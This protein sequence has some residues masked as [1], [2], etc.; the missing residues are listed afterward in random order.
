LA[1]LVMQ[2]VEIANIS[3]T[4]YRNTVATSFAID[5]PANSMQRLDAYIAAGFVYSVEFSLAPP[6]SYFGLEA[7]FSPIANLVS[8]DCPSSLPPSVLPATGYDSEE[9]GDAL[10]YERRTAV[11]FQHRMV[12]SLKRTSSPATRKSTA[13]C[14]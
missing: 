8:A 9:L 5:G 12:R 7:A 10:H 3:T 2:V 14:C 11:P 6:C 13:I 4:G 1:N